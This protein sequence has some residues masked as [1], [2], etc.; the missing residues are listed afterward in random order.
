MVSN[1]NSNFDL[2]NHLIVVCCHAIY[3]GGSRLGASED[4]WLVGSEQALYME[5]INL[6]HRAG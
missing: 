1:P 4:E 2:C 5:D 6:M 3:I